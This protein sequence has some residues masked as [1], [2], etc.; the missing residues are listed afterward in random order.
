MPAPDVPQREASVA[1]KA[2]AIPKPSASPNTESQRAASS[3][4]ASYVAPTPK[5]IPKPP[6]PRREGKAQEKGKRETPPWREWENCGRGS[7]ETAPWRE[8]KGR[9]K[10]GGTPSHR[11]GDWNYTGRY[12]DNRGWRSFHLIS[13]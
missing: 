8:N 3:T 2:K 4:D 5:Q 6:P 1:A 12:Q 11:G 7:G 13:A 10:S 9:G